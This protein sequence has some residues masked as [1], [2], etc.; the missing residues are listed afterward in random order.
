MHVTKFEERSSRGA[1]YPSKRHIAVTS[2]GF[3]G[4]VV[5]R[6]SLRGGSLHTDRNTTLGQQPHG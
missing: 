5:D 4:Y 2:A 6:R 3:R 1:A